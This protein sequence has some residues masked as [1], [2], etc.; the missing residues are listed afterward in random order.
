MSEQ[1]TG[2]PDIRA[3]PEILLEIEDAGEFSEEFIV[4]V[5]EGMWFAL[6]EIDIKQPAG[7]KL[8]FHSSPHTYEVASRTMSILML[9]IRIDPDSVSYRDVLLGGFAAAFHDIEQE[10]YIEEADD[11]SLVRRSITPD[12]EAASAHRAIEW[13]NTY[14]QKSN[15]I[16]F[17][18]KD[19]DQVEDAIIRT[20]PIWVPEVGAVHQDTHGADSVAL[21]LCLADITS[22]GMDVEGFIED[23]NRLFR[24][25]NPGLIKRARGIGAFSVA[26]A[27]EKAVVWTSG[28]KQFVQ[29]RMHLA[30]QEI[31]SSGVPQP[32]KMRLYGAI[33]K[34]DDTLKAV[35]S[36][37]QIRKEMSFSD[38]IRS[39]GYETED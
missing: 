16:I 6:G 38:L 15:K 5:T 31:A 1:Y 33:N 12:N 27:A 39:L 34:F 23:G 10:T 28:Q 20:A 17:T 29:G 30:R 2:S 18:K 19:M 26:R 36:L 13:M 24:E 4:A 8:D 21:A 37:L 3:F 25:Q 7:Y 35:D 32:I 9:M 22:C 11:G 14:N